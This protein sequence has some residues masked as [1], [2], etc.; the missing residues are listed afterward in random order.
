MG[1]VLTEQKN[2]N[3]YFAPMEA[4]AENAIRNKENR[5]F[6]KIEAYAFD[7]VNVPRGYSQII[8]LLAVTNM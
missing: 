7:L 4:G 2:N 6:A 3:G 5:L 1:M 8:S